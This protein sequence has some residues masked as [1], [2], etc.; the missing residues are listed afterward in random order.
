[1]AVERYYNEKNELGVL[2]SP[3]FGGGWS[4]ES[5]EEFAYDK[6]IVEYWLT[7]HP[8]RDDMEEFI[9]N[10]GYKNP[11]LSMYGYY[12]LE[13]AWIPKGTLFYI[14]NYNEAETII[15]EGFIVA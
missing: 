2:Y 12:N 1:V 4:T 8:L 6:R 15:Q 9:E 14:E 7:E 11:Y 10:I 13:I 5:Y 3:G